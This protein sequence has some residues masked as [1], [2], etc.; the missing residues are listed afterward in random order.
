M[1]N[2]KLLIS[3]Q[4]RDKLS[5]AK[6]VSKNAKIQGIIS[7]VLKLVVYTGII[8]GALTL[9]K[10]FSL[11]S[12]DAVIPLNAFA[13][14]LSFMLLLSVIAS[15]KSII[16]HLYLAKDNQ[17]LFTLPV[18]RTELFFSK[19]I[20]F[21]LQDLFRNMTFFLPLLIAI[22]L[23]NSFSIW[24][25]LWVPVALILI[26]L[27]IS[28]VSALI[29]IPLSFVNRFIKGNK[30]LNITFS[31]TAITLAVL[32]LFALIRIIPSD[33]NLVEQWSIVR[34]DIDAFL[35]TVPD[36][37]SFLYAINTAFVGRMKG[38]I[39]LFFDV[40]QLLAIL[41]VVLAI[42][43]I[44]AA[45]VFAA[46]PIFFH[47]AS[48]TNEYKREMN[49]KEKKNKKLNS[50]FTEVKKEL[51]LSVRNSNKFTTLIYMALAI[52]LALF[53]LNK[54]FSVMDVRLDGTNMIYAF[55][56]LMILLIS[57][58]SNAMLAKTFSEDGRAG[59]LLKNS[60]S[61]PI[62]PLTARISLNAIIMTISILIS[63]II[64]GVMSG[65]SAINILLM[66]L[67]IEL[68]YISHALSSALLDLMNPQNEH[69]ATSGDSFNN[70][71]EGKATLTSFLI[72][73]VAAFLVFFFVAEN[74][75]SAWY[76]VLIFAT[77]Y[78]GWTLYIYIKKIKIYY[79]EK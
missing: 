31:I 68:F 29:S 37:F 39:H 76:K 6:N 51:T 70:P 32:G 21:I 18:K 28:A 3:M 24:F 58:S 69:Y 41:Y 2:L 79:Q 72:S 46:K 60:P 52:P 43:G 56:V 11:I 62:K 17:F 40:D 34:T 47:M 4:L 5:L 63:T 20:V 1:S 10:M 66:F 14:L 8:Y 54:V 50:F 44:F 49:V 27:L 65:L 35:A 42:V 71:N 7:Q 61:N 64:A 38:S 36:R 59:Y 19:L 33:I 75:I 26:T 74:Y 53:L 48:K 9:I 55:N 23:V 16:N 25:F 13:L 77:L 73:A 15:T 22:G 45:V 12:T 78:F 57:S 67:I 30:V